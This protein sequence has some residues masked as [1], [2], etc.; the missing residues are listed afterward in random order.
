MQQE[1]GRRT[2]AAVLE[3]AT[4]LIAEVGWGRVSTRAVADRAGVR[5]GVVHYHFRSQQELLAEAATGA[6]AAM[7]QEWLALLQGSDGPEQ[8]LHR[9]VG[10]LAE[11]SPDHPMH[12][13][14]AETYLAASRD[15][16]VAERLRGVLVELRGGLTRWLVEQ[17][18]E[19]TTAT[20]L[21][22]LLAAALDG[23]ALHRGLDPGLP[24]GA[25]PRL[26]G[27]VLAHADRETGGAR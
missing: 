7:V 6:I 13:L 17:G 9:G 16:S 10:A 3:A 23:L 22:P 20:T 1:R 14:F 8:A 26:L 11:L 15:E 27:P 4:A 12:L 18:V 5:A 19:P 25:L 2:R 24:L 21:A